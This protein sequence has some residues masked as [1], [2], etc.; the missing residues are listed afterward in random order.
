M[1]FDVIE[2]MKCN[3]NG[4]R[5]LHACVEERKSGALPKVTKEWVDTKDENTMYSS[6]LLEHGVTPWEVVSCPWWLDY[7]TGIIPK[8]ETSLRASKGF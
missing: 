8:Q 3:E 2:E 7:P 4:S 5:W 6:T 1:L